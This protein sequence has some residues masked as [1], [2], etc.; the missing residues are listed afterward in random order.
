MT[1]YEIDIYPVSPGVQ[2][3]GNVSDIIVGTGSYKLTPS[4][5]ISATTPMT[6]AQIIGIQ[7]Y[8]SC[9]M[10]GKNTAA[11]EAAITGVGPT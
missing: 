10:A 9:I 6:Q 4:G 8:L 5:P 2:A 11:I 3:K 1:T 7:G